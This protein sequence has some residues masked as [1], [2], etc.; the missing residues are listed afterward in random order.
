MRYVLANWKMYTTVGEAVALFGTVQAGLRSRAA[1]GGRLPLPI[2]CPP[3]V[4]LAPVRD[5]ADDDLVRL[6]AQNCH[7]EREGPHTGEISPAMLHD[8][9]SYVLIG[10]SERRAA[11]ETDEQIARKVAAAAE[12]GLVPILFVGEEEPTGDA[13]EESE[14][15]L[16]RGLAR[17]DLTRHRVMVV[18]EPAWAV[19]ADQAADTGH[20][21]TVVE[22]LKG[23]LR[24]RGT[25]DP[26]VLYGGT[27]TDENIDDFTTLDVLDGVGATRASLDAETFL[28]LVDRVA[29]AGAGGLGRPPR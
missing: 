24:Q 20:V 26:D 21:G 2:I 4:S 10:H 17:V 3:F 1:R 12:V 23:W 19:G 27:V 11:G 6:G 13:A 14:Q 16:G 9:V 18:Y 7:W 5:L 8:L 28:A 15:Q 25:S 29:G 22:R